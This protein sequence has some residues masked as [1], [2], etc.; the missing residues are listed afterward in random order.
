MDEPNW[1]TTEITKLDKQTRKQLGKQG[2]LAI[3]DA[4][5]AGYCDAVNAGKGLDVVW[6]VDGGHLVESIVGKEGG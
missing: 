6:Y 5:Y 4:I 3:L 1:R 2:L